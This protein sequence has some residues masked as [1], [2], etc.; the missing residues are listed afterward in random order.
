MKNYRVPLALLVV[1]LAV[2]GAL[3]HPLSLALGLLPWDTAP[4]ISRLVRI[5]E[6]IADLLGWGLLALLA[7]MLVYIVRGRLARR[8]IVSK[9]T[10]QNNG[11]G[12]LDPRVVVVI[13]GYNDA[14]ATAQAVRD[15]SLQQG[16]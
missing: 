3:L 9:S 4:L 14:E 16:I 6:M 5:R 13:T 8:T 11:A 2:L 15:F 7:V 10:T 1:V 12:I